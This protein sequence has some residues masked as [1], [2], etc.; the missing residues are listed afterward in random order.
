MPAVGPALFCGVLSCLIKVLT[1]IKLYFV[2][3]IFFCIALI[4]SIAGARVARA[5]D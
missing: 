2:H 1:S 4:L 5:R 3:H